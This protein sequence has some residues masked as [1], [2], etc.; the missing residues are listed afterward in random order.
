VILTVPQDAI[1][2]PT[3]GPQVC[4]FIEQNLVFGPGDLRGQPV[5][6]DV[7]KIA[8]IYRMYEVFPKGHP[9]AGRRRFKRVG[10]SLPKGLGKTELAAWIA[11][12]ELHPDAPVRCVGF[13]D[14]G[15]PI[16]GPVTDPYIPL[17]AYNEEQSDELC[18][19]AMRTVCEEGPL[20]DDFDIGLERIMRKRGDGKAEALSSSPNARDGA[21]TTFSVMDETHRWVL[22]RLKLAHQTMSANLAKRKLADPWMLEITTAPE[23]GAG[24]VAEMTMEYANQVDQGRVANAAFFYF[25]Q[26]AGD[27]HDLTTLEGLRAAVV[28]AS[29]SAAAWRDIDGIMALFGDPTADRAY[30][31]RVWLNQLVQSSTQAFDAEQWK[32]L[33]D[34]AH[35]VSVRAQIALGFDGSVRHD[36]TAL[37]ATELITGY[38]WLVGL[39]E[40]PYGRE[41][42][43]VPT[44]EVDQR[45][46]ETFERYTVWR[47]YADPFRWESRVA[48]WAGAFG[49]ERVVFWETNRP[50]PMA[51]ACVAFHNAIME[52]LISHDG[53]GNLTR[54]IGN[55]RKDDSAHMVDEQGKPLWTIRKERP[56]SPL[57]IDAAM[58]A[59]LSWKARTD[60]VAAGVTQSRE[61]MLMF[62][63]GR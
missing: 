27:T 53:D 3:L 15:E 60:A 55:A 40:R 35:R 4:D 50:R 44:G 19:G 24:S 54:H 62:L 7:E 18:F 11:V 20:K 26:Q 21:R 38:Q 43:E 9:L 45:V 51:L 6:L 22:P 63:G 28:E 58:A 34:S 14:A 1:L 41:E 17:V 23:P 30:L 8:L 39:W 59:I 48:D 2:Y 46:R 5:V 25:H 12:C 42:W 29:G 49:K 31:Q 37:V 61:P 16:G 47:M 13:T 56:D 57:K 36:A 10:V 52:G 32:R 33:A